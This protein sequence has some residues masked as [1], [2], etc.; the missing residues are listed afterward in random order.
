MTQVRLSYE[1]LA[2]PDVWQRRVRVA[3]DHAGSM[4]AAARALG[5]SRDTMRKWCRELRIPLGEPGRKK[6]SETP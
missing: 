1:R 6:R 3:I 4:A 2:H 5:V